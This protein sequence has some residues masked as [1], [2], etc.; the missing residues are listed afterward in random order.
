LAQ[1]Y[2]P[3][4]R[5]TLLPSHQAKN[6]QHLT[7]KIQV[8]AKSRWSQIVDGL[9]DNVLLL[10]YVTYRASKENERLKKELTGLKRN[11]PMSKTVNAEENIANQ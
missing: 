6:K 5:G 9:A 2:P 4:G 10:A 7:Q 8:S 1:T 3:S 11:R